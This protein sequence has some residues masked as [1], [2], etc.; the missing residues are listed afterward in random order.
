MGF[1]N[2]VFVIR[3]SERN[4]I[5]LSIGAACATKPIILG[6]DIIIGVSLSLQV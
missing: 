3:N 2:G 6:T 5:Y 4:G 1:K